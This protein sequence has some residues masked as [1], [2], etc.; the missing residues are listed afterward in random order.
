MM[1]VAKASGIAA[2]IPEGLPPSDFSPVVAH[3]L[4][5]REQGRRCWVYTMVTSA[6]RIAAA[7]A[8]IGETLHGLDFVLTGEALTPAKRAAI[9]AS[10]A[11]VRQVYASTE[12]ALMAL[13]CR[14]AGA[15]CLHLLTDTLAVIRHRRAAELSDC[16]VDSLFFTALL[17]SSP[18]FVI[19]LEMN[20]NGTLGQ[21]TC[22]CSLARLGLTTTIQDVFSF[23]KLTGMGVTL[24]GSQLLDLLERTLPAK[25]G[26]SPGDYQLLE[27]DEGGQHRV[28]LRISPRAGLSSPDEAKSSFLQ[29]VDRLYG[30]RVTRR[31]WTH[32][33]ALSVE[34]AEPV[35]TLSGKVLPL[36]L[37][38]RPQ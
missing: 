29:I 15:D 33:G 5:R 28:T 11:S 32:A 1:L 35:A 10:G 13:P 38:R 30:G 14:Q 4:R 21:A 34:I 6:V 7:A 25:F 18:Y 2:P 22:D 24:L 36:H 16:Q 31:V 20:D 12:L 19:N 26:G 27:S 9:E 17:P 3:I 23:G 8:D 37:L